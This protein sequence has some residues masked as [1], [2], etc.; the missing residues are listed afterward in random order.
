[1]KPDA[2][3]CKPGRERVQLI[4][5]GTLRHIN[6]INPT[7]SFANQQIF[8]GVIYYGTSRH[9][10]CHDTCKLKHMK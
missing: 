8:E 10:T 6:H 1:M 2:K 4:Y 9:I 5:Y 7:L 3:F